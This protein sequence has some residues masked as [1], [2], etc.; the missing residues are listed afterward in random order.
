MEQVKH[1]EVSP[2][3]RS[4]GFASSRGRESRDTFT[5]PGASGER[6]T[7]STRTSAASDSSIIIRRNFLQTS[8]PEWIWVLT[9]LMKLRESSKFRTIINNFLKIKIFNSNRL[10]IGKIRDRAIFVLL[11]EFVRQKRP[12]GGVQRPRTRGLS[13]EH[14][15]AD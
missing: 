5:T 1:D 8:F 14:R 6:S 11:K 2:E 12:R 7:P 15:H 4:S 10:T 13:H 9:I 3:Q